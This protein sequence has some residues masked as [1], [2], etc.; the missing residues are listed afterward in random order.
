MASRSNCQ[1]KQSVLITQIELSRLISMTT[2]VTGVADG[3]HEGHPLSLLWTSFHKGLNYP[4]MEA[5]PTRGLAE[6][7]RPGRS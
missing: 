4:E 2:G 5:R 7:L 6:T 1:I 3:W